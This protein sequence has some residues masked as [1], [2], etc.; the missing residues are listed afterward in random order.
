SGKSFKNRPV[1]QEMRSKLRFGDTLIV[2]DLSRLGRDKEE[3]KREWQALIQEDI[4]IAVL[5]MP[6]LDTR[7]YKDIK[8]LE[9]VISNIDLE[10]LSWLVDEERERIRQAQREGIEIAKKQ[11]KYKGRPLKYHANATGQDKI[12]YDDII[13]RLKSGQSVMDIHLKTEVSRNTIY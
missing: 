4:D 12:I 13:N 6:I 5:N 7:K 8:G 3:I 11:G 2:H 10:L 1:Y 9:N